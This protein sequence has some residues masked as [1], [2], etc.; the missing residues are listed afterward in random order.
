MRC[1]AKVMGRGWA[2]IMGLVG[3]TN[4]CHKIP[5]FCLYRLDVDALF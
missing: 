4:R 3:L 5:R 1:I 2:W